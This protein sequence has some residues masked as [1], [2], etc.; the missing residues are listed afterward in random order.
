MKKGMAVLLSILMLLGGSA[1]QKAGGT[2]TGEVAMPDTHV[3]GQAVEKKEAPPGTTS[4]PQKAETTTKILEK[5]TG[6]Q[7]TKETP[8]Y[9][10]SLNTAVSKAKESAAIEESKT[11]ASG[12]QAAATLETENTAEEETAAEAPVFD[13]MTIPAFL[14]TPQDRKAMDL[15]SICANN[16]YESATFLPDGSLTVKIDRR[17][18]LAY[19]AYM[20]AALEEVFN[21]LKK[22]P[23]S[24]GIQN[25]QMGKNYGTLRIILMPNAYQELKQ[26]EAF[27]NISLFSLV[28]N[29]QIYSLLPVDCTLEY[30]DSVTGNTLERLSVQGFFKALQSIAAY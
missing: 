18:R 21:E 29:Y 3:E 4:I 20:Q 10:D 30:V 24:S 28:V 16:G 19:L 13:E 7:N 2:G 12:T 23:A 25:I 11:P 26:A 8:K 17:S 15:K 6:T 14:Y 22:D 9:T 27:L 1:C 5:T